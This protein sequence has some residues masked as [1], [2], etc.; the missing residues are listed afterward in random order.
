MW[1]LPQ[2]RAQLPTAATVAPLAKEPATRPVESAATTDQHFMPRPPA[3]EKEASPH[4]VQLA[5]IAKPGDG[6]SEPRTTTTGSAISSTPIAYQ[7]SV[8]KLF[9]TLPHDVTSVKP[10]LL[11]SIATSNHERSAHKLDLQQRLTRLELDHFPV[12]DPQLDDERYSDMSLDQYMEFAKTMDLAHL[13]H[14]HTKLFKLVRQYQGLFAVASSISVEVDSNGALARIVEGVHRVLPVD[15]VVLLLLNRK[16]NMLCGTHGTTEIELPLGAG[17]EGYVVTQ[18]KSIM[19]EDAPSDPR[20]DP[21]M[22]RLTRIATVN[23]LCVPVTGPKNQVVAVLHCANKATAFT[24][25]DCLGLELIAMIAGHTLHKLEMFDSAVSTGRRTSA[26]LQVVKT[27]AEENSDIHTMIQKVIHVAKGA[28]NCDRLTF[29]LCNNVKRELICCVYKD[30]MLDRFCMSYDVGLAGY[31]ATTG[32]PVRVEDCYKEP[33]FNPVV[34]EKSSYRSVSSICAPVVSADGETIAVVQALNK[35]TFPIPDH[36]A[37]SIPRSAIA[38]F[39]D[40]D[41]QL[42]TAFCAEMAVSLRR[43]TLEVLYHKMLQEMSQTR[44]R[45][46]V[47]LMVSSLLGVHSNEK[48]SHTWGIKSWKISGLVSLAASKFMKTIVKKRSEADLHDKDAPHEL[49][50]SI[51]SADRE[52]P[53]SAAASDKS[54]ALAA[55]TEKLMESVTS[56]AVLLHPVPASH[57]WR[58]K[59]CGFDD[60]SFDIFA[61]SQDQLG[62]LVVEGFKQMGLLTIFSVKESVASHFVHTVRHSYYDN[63]YHSWWHGAD[64]FQHVFALLNR[65]QLLS[66]LQPNIVFSMLVAALCHDIGHPGTDN[67]YEIATGSALAMKYNDMSVLEQHHACETFRILLLPECNLFVGM[68]RPAFQTVRKLIIDGILQTDMKCHFDLVHDLE[69]AVVRKQK[70]VQ[71]FDISNTS[72]VKWMVGAILHASDIGAQTYP[73]AIAGQWSTRLVD[74]FRLLSEKEMA[75]GIPVAPFRDKLTSNKAIGRL[76]L[77]FINY[78]VTP[79][80]HLVMEVFPG[81]A[82][83]RTNLDANRAFFQQMIIEADPLM[84]REQSRPNL[85]Q[86]LSSSTLQSSSLSKSDL[87]RSNSATE[88]TIITQQQLSHQL[89][90][91][92]DHHPIHTLLATGDH[93]SGA[94]PENNRTSFSSV[95]TT[96]S[97]LYVPETSTGLYYTASSLS[98]SPSGLL[99]EQPCLQRSPSSQSSLLSH[100]S[101][102][103]TTNQSPSS[104][105]SRDVILRTPSM[106]QICSSSESQSNATKF[107]HQG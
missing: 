54:I 81:A 53:P 9:E 101:S 15:R 44:R 12:T 5:R 32:Q 8:T 6:E 74:E 21:T 13:R 39:T 84:T 20:F 63:P 92:I 106:T 10:F 50:A 40:S 95:D 99:M 57:E 100:A 85:T 2:L 73:V 89:S 24:N 45:D 62:F 59:Q 36:F 51:R 17:F 28:L 46:S 52:Q 64:V 3:K 4:K 33:R 55:S 37:G 105:P 107:T 1:R 47:T 66:M 103:S 18:C 91:A 96:G 82:V 23:I 30:S 48:A 79:L 31:V 43:S 16:R 19:V 41:V 42:L 76:Q 71:L 86:S 69:D 26:I 67:A 58:D 29:Y 78:I 38:T 35:C 75:Q 98:Q 34:D 83:L 14:H 80:W 93:S 56:H 87:R 60:F 94:T 88:S 104:V 11:P 49:P 72:H 77:N 68:S 22:D 97:L 102:V 61:C 25:S 70:E 7:P 90:M 65:T 27:V